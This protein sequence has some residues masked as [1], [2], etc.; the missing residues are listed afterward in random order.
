MKDRPAIELVVFDIAGTTVHDDDSVNR[1]FRESLASF[2]V[3]AE[4]DQVNRVMGLPKPVAIARLLRQSEGDAPAD[5]DVIHADFVAR[6]IAFYGRDPSVREAR[7]ATEVFRLLTAAGV[8]VA[9]DTGFSRAIADVIL[10]R[11]GWRDRS[12]VAATIC[13]DE[14][15]RGRPYPDMIER[16]MKGLDVRNAGR[17]AKVGDT[18]SDLEEGSSA[19]CGLVV[20]IAGATHTRAQ[21]AAYP[22]THLID[23]LPE[24]PALLGL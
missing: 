20:G 17:V 15:A 9:L 5:V 13:S 21:L 6:A 16:L 11:L 10:D 7:G 14:V 18:P 19:G 1:I 8:K 23:S 4:P 3:E 24:F 22:H 12:L 2:G